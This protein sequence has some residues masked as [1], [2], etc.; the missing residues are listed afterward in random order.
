MFEIHWQPSRGGVDLGVGRRCN[1]SVCS[2]LDICYQF[3]HSWPLVLYQLALPFWQIH[4]YNLWDLL[5][6]VV[7]SDTSYTAEKL[8]LC[9][10]S[11]ICSTHSL[12]KIQQN[13][14]TVDRINWL[15]TDGIP[16]R[17]CIWSKKGILYWITGKQN[18]SFSTFCKTAI[19]DP[20]RRLLRDSLVCSFPCSW[21]EGKKERK[22]CGRC[23]G[24]SV[25]IIL[26]QVCCMFFCV[27]LI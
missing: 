19:K 21:K 11:L 18:W 5:P 8:S 26:P 6:S 12:L 16:E 9:P 24:L 7:C 10:A 22:G 14:W 27:I 25:E 2:V 4:D 13:K 1:N 15:W 20:C 3:L 17:M 23:K